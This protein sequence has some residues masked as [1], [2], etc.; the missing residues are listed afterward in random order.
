[1]ATVAPKLWK[2]PDLQGERH[3]LAVLC[4]EDVLEIRR[5]RKQ[6]P[7]RWTYVALAN[8]FNVGNSTIGAVL[9]NRT[10]QHLLPKEEQ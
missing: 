3:H 7:Q 9:S 4:A 10:W 5:L 6:N 8:E 2:R 1:M